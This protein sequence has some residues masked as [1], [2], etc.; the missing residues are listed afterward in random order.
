MENVVDD[1]FEEQLKEEIMKKMAM[2]E[3]I[4]TYNLKRS[5]AQQKVIK[6][7]QEKQEYTRK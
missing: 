6:M 5:L 4:T 3:R 1:R 7:A 2:Q